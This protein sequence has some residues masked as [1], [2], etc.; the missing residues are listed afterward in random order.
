MPPN[1]Y[2]QPA[3]TRA[4]IPTP[5]PEARM[6]MRRTYLFIPLM[7]VLA[8]CQDTTAPRVDPRLAG[9]GPHFAQ[10][11]G[12]V[13]TVNSLA[14][15]GDGT[16]DDTECTLRE[17]IAAVPFDGNIVFASAVQGNILLTSGELYIHNKDLTINGAGRITIDAQ[18]NSRVIEVTGSSFGFITPV[19]RLA[20]LT[21]KNGSAGHGGGISAEDLELLTLDSVTV[22]ANEAAGNG[23]G[24]YAAAAEVSI[25]N[26]SVSNNIGGDN[27]GGIASMDGPL[28][29]INS[30]VD[31]NRADDDSPSGDFG[32]GGGIY[33][34][35]RL[36]VTGSSISGNQVSSFSSS[37]I[38]NF[39]RGAGVYSLGTARVTA[40]TIAVNTGNDIGTG[41]FY[42]I[43]DGAVSFFRS[44][45]SDNT[46][47]IVGG[48][49]DIQS[50]TI[51]R[52]NL[53]AGGINTQYP[54]T[55]A[56]SVVAG[57][58]YLASDYAVECLAP[59]IV[60]LG[61]NLT[62]VGSVSPCPF[63]ATGDIQVSW[64]QVHTQV[65]ESELKFNGGPTRTHA[66]I[67][68]G[69]AVDAG[70]CP[71]EIIDQRGFA[72]PVDDAIMPNSLDGCD[73]G[74]YELQ[75]AVA[76]LMVS[77]TVDK[78]S[79]KQGD[80]LTYYVRVQNF[81]PQTAPNVVLSDIL[82]SG[83]TFY[84]ASGNKGTFTAPPRGET[85]TVTW[86]LGD[87]LNQANE[88]AQIAVTVLVKGNT[89]ITNTATAT[90][91]VADPNS[92]NNSAA[93]TVSV[94]LS[95]GKTSGG[96]TGG[97]GGGGGGGGGGNPHR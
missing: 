43:G 69:L 93:I 5:S 48:T 68:R 63:S 58:G 82:S 8:A 1:A 74:A 65:V 33:N 62:S 78:T 26:S 52:N 23:G 38:Y 83:V 88:V 41:G 49:L 27:G 95:G 79:V 15:P 84:S 59:H 6:S 24:L 51:T 81:G 21:L 96:G 34:R 76:D 97:T 10:G 14:D 77:Q 35:G 46:G 13:W 45:I 72:R 66:L 55:V 20:G 36:V 29:L 92:A 2:S 57:N 40:S 25:L 86:S 12:G 4:P 19:V 89:T 42:T 17:A 85:G 31:G 39:G 50:S 30:K 16:C 67:S 60:S 73:I 87:M 80:L 70:Y 75:R 64:N 90:G 28:T 7:L 71:G 22:T 91:N 9:L 94:V 18:H 53:G 3:I 47:G 44:T 61:H 37:S 32:K 56:N 54:V 11:D